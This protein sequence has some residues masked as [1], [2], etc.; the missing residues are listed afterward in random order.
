VVY[1]KKFVGENDNEKIEKAVAERGKDGFVV[2][3]PKTDGTPWILDRAILLPENT[4]FI[5]RNCKIKLSDSCRDNF[6]RTANC[7][8]GIDVPEKIRNI[9]IIGEGRA[10]LEGADHPRAVG[11]S[12]KILA[13]PCPYTDED[14]CKYADWVDEDRRKSGIL[15]FADKHGRSYG[16]DAGKEGESQFGDWRGIGILFANVED[17]QIENL[18]IVESHGW[19]IS[20]EAGSYGRISKIDFDARMSKK[21]DGMLQNM[22]NQDGI[23]IRNGCHHITISDIT[24]MTGDDVIALTAIARRDL[25]FQSGGSLCSTHVMNNDW[26]NRVSDIHD[27]TIKNV[28]ATSYHCWVARLLSVETKIYNVIID[29]VIDT[30]K[31]D[32]SVHI[33]TIYL[34]KNG[35]G[36]TRNKAVEYLENII[37]SNVISAGRFGVRV[38]GFV[39]RS[40][41]ENVIHTNPNS[42]VFTLDHEDDLENVTIHN[43]K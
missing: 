13:N 43:V 21:I 32:N 38:G 31:Q 27:I 11:D 40:I 17:F 6:F 26:E 28:M 34:N 10:I 36:A 42:P 35:Y 4:F 41:I 7:G 29:N 39:K 5:V 15:N 9:R 19:G 3:E 25:G 8:M 24:G 12:T 20:I 37:V 2:L 22:E 23:D 30:C 14:L 18:R 16:T 1:V 33:G